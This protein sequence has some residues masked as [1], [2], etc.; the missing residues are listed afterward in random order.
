MR[1]GAETAAA[2]TGIGGVG[3]VE[4]E[5]TSHD[6][7]LEIDLGAIE[8]EITLGITDHGD[9][10]AVLD[11]RIGVLVFPALVAVL[12][13]LREI[14]QVAETTAT[15]TLDTDSEPNDCGIEVLLLDD[16]SDLPGGET[17]ERRN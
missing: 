16:R 11:L 4:D 15:T 7:V 6:L 9:D 17:R 2:A 3:I 13:V 1:S 8:V 5:S 10:P 12:A 14:Q